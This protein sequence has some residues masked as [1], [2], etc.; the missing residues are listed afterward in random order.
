MDPIE[1]NNKQIKCL[2][3]NKKFISIILTYLSQ[4]I[5]IKLNNIFIPFGVEKFNNK[6]ILNLEFDKNINTH[7]NYVS[8]LSSLENKINNKSYDTEINV[9]SILV[10]KIFT[11][12]L[13]ESILGHILRT[14]I[15]DST[16]IFILKKDLSKM[17]IDKENLKGTNVNI[18]LT[19]KGLWVNDEKYGLYW[20]I[21][22]IQI[23]KFN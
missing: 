12:S 23:T 3:K 16:E 9:E 19:L 6:N 14:H 21:N 2:P 20:N 5:K 18:E 22:N 8:V 15:T 7:N 11:T 13:K 10:N 17:Q 4:I 1:L